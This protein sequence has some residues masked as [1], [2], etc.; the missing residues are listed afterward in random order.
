MLLVSDVHGAWPALRA[1]ASQ[2][3]PLLVLGDLV[4]LVDYRTM[5]G[6]M[7][8]IYGKEM[9]AEVSHLR[10]SGEYRAAR[11]RWRKARS[12]R[13]DEIDLRFRAL[14]EDSY[15][16]AA[17]AL[18][19]CEAYVTYGN[20]D[21]PDLLAAMLPEGARF[22]DGDVVEVEGLRIGVAGG[23]IGPDFGA[24][25]IVTEE[26]M[27]SKLAGLGD[28][29]ILCTHAAPAVRQL[30]NDVVAGASKHSEAVHQFVV[31]RQPTHHYFGDVHQPQATTW[32]VGRTSCRNVGYFRATGRP[33]RHG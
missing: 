14:L 16:Q 8:Q 18:A 19:G 1:A 33:V 7:S 24:P 31:D 28:V 29:D 13:E 17:A 20:V 2:G 12:G 25:G 10:A 30:S 9:V 5:D 11:A 27:A 21:T 4:N 26:Q 3:E 6:I 23:G 15:R 32:R 22:V